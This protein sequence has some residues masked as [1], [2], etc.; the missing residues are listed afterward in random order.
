MPVL[1][2]AIKLLW[3]RISDVAVFAIELYIYE[4]AVLS[5]LDAIVRL[6][7]RHLRIQALRVV[8]QPS[9]ALD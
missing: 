3:I 4:G 8:L 5:A 1:G 6:S 2:R 7:D 9:A